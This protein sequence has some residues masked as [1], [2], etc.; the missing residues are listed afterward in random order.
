VPDLRRHRSRGR[1]APVAVRE[2]E[3]I[4]LTARFG[5]LSYA[6]QAR[7]SGCAVQHPASAELCAVH[8]LLSPNKECPVGSQKML[9]SKHE[10][11]LPYGLPHALSSTRRWQKSISVCVGT[12]SLGQIG[13]VLQGELPPQAARASV[14][15]MASNMVFIDRGPRRSWIVQLVTMEDA[16]PQIS[17]PRNEAGFPSPR[18]KKDQRAH[19]WSQRVFAELERQDRAG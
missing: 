4:A 17:P 19:A 9:A 10:T 14:P 15:A 11:Q 6:P 1:W 13:V 12:G 16:A 5:F 2:P 7:D 8:L 3:P 18:P